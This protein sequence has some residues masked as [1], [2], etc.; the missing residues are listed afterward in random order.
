[1]AG[2]RLMRGVIV[3][4][5]VWTSARAE[6]EEL[7]RVRVFLELEDGVVHARRTYGERAVVLSLE[8]DDV[9]AALAALKHEANRRPPKPI[10]GQTELVEPDAEAGT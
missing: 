5:E 7:E 3:E 9:E 4:G 2:M 8:L 10:P 6:A 1:V